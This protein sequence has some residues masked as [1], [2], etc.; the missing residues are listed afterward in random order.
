MRTT[1]SWAHGEATGETDGINSGEVPLQ[2]IVETDI[3]S[4]LLLHAGGRWAC[5]VAGAPDHDS[6]KPGKGL[7][8]GD[9]EL[10]LPAF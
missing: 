5:R 7:I 6:G 8:Q 10:A 4:V 1:G 2:G 3:V 9:C